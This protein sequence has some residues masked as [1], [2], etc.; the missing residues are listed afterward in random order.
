[1]TASNKKQT[2]TY[3]ILPTDSS[4]NQYVFE[5]G[6]GEITANG[7]PR[8]LRHYLRCPKTKEVIIR[9]GVFFIP[10]NANAEDII[11]RMLSAMRDVSSRMMFKSIAKKYELWP[12]WLNDDLPALL[13][14]APKYVWMEEAINHLFS[15]VMKTKR[16]YNPD[17]NFPKRSKCIENL[18]A[19]FG[20]HELSI[21]RTMAVSMNALGGK[22]SARVEY[23]LNSTYRRYSDVMPPQLTLTNEYPLNEWPDVKTFFELPNIKPIIEA[24]VD[25]S[26][27]KGIPAPG[28]T[29]SVDF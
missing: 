22:L 28:A 24:W 25:H 4:E 12:A 2:N 20:E 8:A 3:C 13:E 9:G 16:L 14:A 15:D 5:Y 7:N 17:P 10:T 23:E 27:A 21:R 26:W 11:K 29:T 1:M 6:E 19:F 18:R